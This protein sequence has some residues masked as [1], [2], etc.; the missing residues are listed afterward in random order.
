MSYVLIVV[1]WLGGAVNGA[2]VSTPGVYQCGTL[3]DSPALRWFRTPRPAG[4]RTRSGQS[5][6]RSEYL[7]L[8]MA[9]GLVIDS[10]KPLC[11]GTKKQRRGR[12]R[13][14]RPVIFTCPST[15]A[16]RAI[17]RRTAPVVLWLG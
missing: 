9:F 15:L 13:P 11:S 5:A 8:G 17:V 12:Y 14:L 16:I 3:R 6:C 4:L 7:D 1:G 2:A 10:E